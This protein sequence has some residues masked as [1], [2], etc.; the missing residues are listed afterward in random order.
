[1]LFQLICPAS[2]QQLE[3][4]L[5]H[6]SD[7]VKIY[8]RD[9]AGSNVNEFRA[10]TEIRTSLAAL[11]ALLDDTPS[12]TSW[13]D[14][15]TAATLFKEIAPTERI[16]YFQMQMP[17][18]AKRDLIVHSTVT[19]ESTSGIVTVQMENAGGLVPERAGHVRIKQFRGYWQF[20][21]LNDGSKRVI[22]QIYLTPGGPLSNWGFIVNPRLRNQIHHTLL[23]LREAV[24]HPR[25]REAKY[26]G[27]REIGPWKN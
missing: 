7:E 3:W 22:Y 16:T 5:V 9:V 19:Q 25:Y 24:K 12:Y 17:F 23:N 4:R 14:S 27:L 13:L 15:C 8:A 26:E 20:I 2:A 1:M 18:F 10:R 21:P 11:V 6:D